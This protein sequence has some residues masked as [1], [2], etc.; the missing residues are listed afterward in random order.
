MLTPKRV[1]RLARRAG[2]QRADGSRGLLARRALGQLTA[3]V[4]DNYS[5]A[6]AVFE[7]WLDGLEDETWQALASRPGTKRLALSAAVDPER[8]AG[9]REAIG[10]FCTGHGLAPDEP[11]AR[12]LFHVLTGQQAQHRAADPDGSLLAAG[13]RAGTKAI[14]AAVREALAGTGHLDLVRI[15]AGAPGQDRRPAISAEESAYL[16]SQLRARGDWAALWRLA[17]DLSVQPAVTAVAGFP[18][19]WQPADE[20]G[21]ALFRRLRRV[22]PDQIARARATL[23][24]MH[25]EAGGNIESGSLSP[26]GQKLAVAISNHWSLG[27]R[28]FDLRTGAMS[29]AMH[30]GD[31][32]PFYLPP[33]VLHLGDAV[34]V[35]RLRSDGTYALTHHWG[36]NM[37]TIWCVR[38]GASAEALAPHPEGFILLWKPSNKYRLR[39]C[40]AGG[41]ELWDSDEDQI[42]LH[43]WWP[44]GCHLAAVDPASGRLAVCSQNRVWVCEATADHVRSIRTFFT[45][46]WYPSTGCFVAPDCL[47]LASPGGARR[48]RL[49]SHGIL[50][51]AATVFETGLPAAPPMVWLPERGAIALAGE[52]VRDARTLEPVTPLSRAGWAR[53]P[54]LWAAA[55]GRRFV[56]AS[57]TSITVVRHPL[58]DA[59]APLADQPLA[60]LTLAGSRLI[61]DALQITAADSVVRLLLDALA[62]CCEYRFGTEV[63]LGSPGHAHA[64]DDVALGKPA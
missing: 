9:S 54:R 26:D 14:Q 18:R 36:G 40:D 46:G 3:E 30:L 53:A 44:G 45:E 6:R 24:P 57:G 60:A 5:A 28:T 15:V 2:R 64:A 17:Q 13:Y 34:F 61:S 49:A 7:L 27:F 23:A 59:I 43:R 16:V 29:G 1:A 50:R 37:D 48:Y 4:G 33:R 32:R 31:L 38:G 8:P 10:S 47:V 41:N 52:R 51:E 25:I 39:L 63:A 12:A 55:D 21:Q 58:T 62:A 35:G 42:G 22:T 56:F 20:A 19:G 11:A